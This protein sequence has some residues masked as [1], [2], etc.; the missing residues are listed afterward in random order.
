[1]NK[2]ATIIYWSDD[3]QV[4]IAEVP[5]LPGCM[6][7]AETR[8]AALANAEEAI[9]LWVKTAKEFGN[10]VPEPRYGRVISNRAS[11]MPFH[12]SHK[13][14]V[15]RNNVRSFILPGVTQHTVNPEA[16]LK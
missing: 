3:D 16:R 11:K 7:H 4:F 15:R 1:M 6:T 10:Q 14:F 8:S 9:E 12:D 2:Y 13:S 5:D